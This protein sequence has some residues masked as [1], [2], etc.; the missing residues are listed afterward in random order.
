MAAR[1][2]LNVFKT[3]TVIPN[4]YKDRAQLHLE[5]VSRYMIFSEFPLVL[6]TVPLY[7]TNFLM[8]VADLIWD[9]MNRIYHVINTETANATNIIRVGTAVTVSQLTQFFM[10][11][12]MH[13]IC[14][15]SMIP[16][17]YLES[18]LVMI[19]IMDM[20]LP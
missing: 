17:T 10:L 11:Y 1:Q 5:M 2:F 6:F 12:I 3:S 4:C 9:V 7:Q 13:I 14:Q 8:Y 19:K 18:C 20:Q 15:Q 16:G